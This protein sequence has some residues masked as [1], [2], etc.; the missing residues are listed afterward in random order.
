MRRKRVKISVL[1]DSE[2]FDRFDAY[3]HQSGFK[4]SSL[5]ARLIRDHLDESAPNERPKPITNQE[6]AS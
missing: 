1:L 3:C 5:I 6:K 2:E 4:K